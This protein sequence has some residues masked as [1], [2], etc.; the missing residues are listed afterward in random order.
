MDT[1]AACWG[2]ITNTIPAEQ[3]LLLLVAGHLIGD[4]LLQSRAMAEGKRQ[5]P[6][7]LALHALFVAGA[8]AIAL[9]PFAGIAVLGAAIAIGAV[10]GLVDLVTSRWPGSR[11]NALLLFLAD[12]AVH[13]ATLGGAAA[14]LLD[15]AGPLPQ[16]VHPAWM[17]YWLTLFAYVAVFAFTWA[18][19]SGIVVS[20]LATLGPGPVSR[21][22]E[23]GIP[24][25]GR[26]IGGLERTLTLILILLGQW[27][28]IVLL[29]TAKSFARFEELKERR[30]AEY[31]L[32]G[33]LTSLLVAILTGIL[34]RLVLCGSV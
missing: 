14:F 25:S 23:G 29:I 34:L 11:P 26:A 12:Q 24:G 20:A 9:L 22:V 18:G 1:G 32:I 16:H 30:F 27:A 3:V 21:S 8:H 19:G 28:A 4:F 15:A 13:L 5:R 7:T 10:H 17:P 31:Y 2:L 33:T 6:G